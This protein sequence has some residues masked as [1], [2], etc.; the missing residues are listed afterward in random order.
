MPFK[1][2]EERKIYYRS[3][4]LK[5]R[6]KRI[7]DC[8]AYYRSNPPDKEKLSEV[9][10][11]WRAKNKEKLSLIR[12]SW[13]ARNTDRIKRLSHLLYEKNKTQV[14]ARSK[15]WHKN[16]PDKISAISAKKRMDKA[17]ATIKGVDKK[18]IEKFYSESKKR[19]LVSGIRHEVD[20]I[21][22]LRGDG[23]MGLHVPWNLQVLTRHENATKS[24]R[25]PDLIPE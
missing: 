23:F 4:Y 10:K 7:S 6:D 12:K 8:K 13:Y 22:P 19:T 20:H 3:W 16:N 5:N 2:K 1:T 24:N 11:K 21:W 15:S 9:Q 18:E 25:R 14:L 17:S